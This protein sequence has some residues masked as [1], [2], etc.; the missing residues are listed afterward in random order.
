MIYR[1]RHRM[2]SIL[3]LTSIALLAS[4]D[5]AEQTAQQP[6]SA[7]A[8]APA[9]EFAPT[10]TRAAAGGAS[11]AA[12][13]APTPRT[14][15]PLDD[16]QI[17]GGG[18]ALAQE[19]PTPTQLNP[20]NQVLSEYERLV[21]NVYR[22]TINGVVNLSDGNTTG[23]GYVIDA[24]GHIITNNH[25]AANMQEIYVTFADRSTA[26]AR[27]L[28]TFADG[29]IAIVQVEELPASVT[30]VELGDSA[31]L[32]I[33]QIVV[34]I[35]S[36]LGLEQTVTSGIV[37]ALNRSISDI[38]RQES[39]ESE[40]SSLQGLIQTDAAIN[41]GNSGG[42]LFDSAGRVVG[43]NTLIASRAQSNET[44]GNIGLGFAVPINRVKRVARQIIETGEY[45]R[46]R[47]GASVFR[48]YPQIAEQLNLPNA[49]GVILGDITPGGAAEQAGLRGGTQGV[50]INGQTVPID[51]DIITAVNDT[52]VR[53]VG[54]LRNVIETQ[55]D[56]G[57]TITVTFLREG[58]EQQVQVTL[59]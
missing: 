21:N 36:P 15:A 57:D 40:N 19:Q 6:T 31:A 11:E 48:L 16:A 49:S 41:P 59:Q 50:D 28:G 52:P 14:S 53:S 25:V 5:V 4:C 26:Q 30:P 47:L 58:R 33:G 39:Q 8:Q 35:G 56:P 24:Q 9:A 18:V 54:D 3:M 12:Q 13:T 27:L 1:R 17:G 42:P 55:A 2:F 22:R 37:S 29:D 45:R 23:S 51:G 32:Q 7:P 20:S 10:A 46:P 43:M 44:A 34:A 38:S